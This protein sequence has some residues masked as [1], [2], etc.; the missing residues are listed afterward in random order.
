M[1][2]RF[3]STMTVGVG[4]ARLVT[5]VCSMTCKRSGNEAIMHGANVDRDA[6]I[7]D[8]AEVQA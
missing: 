8:G 1:S 5:G 4:A 3:A 6:Y 2:M 7:Q